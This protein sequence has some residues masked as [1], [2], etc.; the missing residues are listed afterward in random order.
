MEGRDRMSDVQNAN[1]VSIRFRMSGAR[2]FRARNTARV[3]CIMFELLLLLSAFMRAIF[4]LFNLQR[5]VCA[6]ALH[7]IRRSR[8]LAM[9]A[10]R[11]FRRRQRR[12]NIRRRFWRLPRPVYSWFDIHF[13]DHA[14]ASCRLGNSS[15]HVLVP[16][17][18]ID[19]TAA[20]FPSDMTRYDPLPSRTS[21]LLMLRWGH[22]GRT[23]LT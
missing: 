4:D 7:N 1:C 21:A 15:E 6:Y 10:Y 2:S 8:I 13:N 19:L 5:I 14:S 11:R 3:D 17:C 22:E 18:L 9:A 12:L 16:G 23:C 20:L